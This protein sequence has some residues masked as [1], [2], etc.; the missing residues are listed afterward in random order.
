MSDYESELLK[1]SKYDLY[2]IFKTLVESLNDSGYEVETPLM[3]LSFE[4][5]QPV[6][7]KLK[8]CR[9]NALLKILKSKKV[10]NKKSKLERIPESKTRS[11]S[12]KDD[13]VDDIDDDE[14]DED[15]IYYDSNMSLF[16]SCLTF[17]GKRKLS[18]SDSKDGKEHKSLLYPDSEGLVVLFSSIPRINKASLEQL[19]KYLKSKSIVNVQLITSQGLTPAAQNS[20]LLLQQ[21]YNILLRPQSSLL[22]NISKHY[23]VKEHK[24]LNPDERKIFM[25]KFDLDEESLSNLPELKVSDPVAIYYDFRPGDIIRINSDYAAENYRIVTKKQL[26]FLKKTGKEE[27]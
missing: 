3:N 12:K 27:S 16:E 9:N 23:L 4:D 25:K 17:F 13:D 18:K 22:V 6:A 1:I 5:F 11:R 14:D 2:R 24:R 15:D 8:K 21:K 7:N 19:S 10:I 26:S 20:L